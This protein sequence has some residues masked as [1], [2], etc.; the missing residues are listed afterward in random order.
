[1][2]RIGLE[3]GDTLPVRVAGPPRGPDAARTPGGRSWSRRQ[4]GV[5]E[6]VDQWCQEYEHRIR[7]ARR[8]RLLSR[9]HRPGR[10]HRLQ[11]PRLGPLLDD[12]AVP[13][14]YETQ[15]AAADGSRR[16]RGLPQPPGDHHRAET[17]T[18]NPECTA[19]IMAAGEAKAEIVAAQ[20]IQSEPNVH[21]GAGHSAAG[22]AERAVLHH[23]G[24]REPD[25][26]AVHA[27][28]QSERSRTATSRRS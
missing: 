6:R 26:A 15:A 18:Y 3:P 12:P 5:L 7:D 16:D 13:T 22:P 23:A 10:P 4:K 24:R 1:M 8:H 11:R 19:I 20:A 28:Q 9:R 21:L 17:I 14:N 2:P 27:L 25:R